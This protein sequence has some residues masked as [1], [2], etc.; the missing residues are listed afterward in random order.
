MAT[1]SGTI[2]IRIYFRVYANCDITQTPHHT[3]KLPMETCTDLLTKGGGGGGAS[4]KSG[5]SCDYRNR[6]GLDSNSNST[7]RTRDIGLSM[8]VSLRKIYNRRTPPPKD[9]P[10]LPVAKEDPDGG[11]LQQPIFK[12]EA[13]GGWVGSGQ[14]RLPSVS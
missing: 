10:S 11:D 7:P 8:T 3:S 14:P 9:P 13:L 6:R 2:E 4:N 5:V 1:D 12:G